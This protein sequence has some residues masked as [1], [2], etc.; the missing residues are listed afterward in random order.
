[1]TGDE[2]KLTGTIV[3]TVSPEPLLIEAIKN[4]RD[5]LQYVVD[6]ILA[7][8]S[9]FGNWRYVKKTGKIKWAEDIRKL[10]RE[11][12]EILKEKYKLPPKLAQNCFR[13]GAFIAKSVL[14]NENNGKKKAIIKK[15]FLRLDN[16]AYRLI[17]NDGWLDSI[18]IQGLC[19]V[20]VMGFPRRQAENYEDWYLG[21][22]IIKIEGKKVKFYLSLNKK[23]RIAHP[24]EKVIAVDP[25]FENIV[26]G[27]L[28]RIR[29]IRTPMQ[30]IMHIKRNH[31]EK[32]QKKYPKSWLHVSGIRKAIKRWWSRIHGILDDFV[33]Q[34]SKEIVRWCKQLGYN[35]IILEDLN[36][37]RDEQA[38][39]SKPWKERF[40]F[41][42]Y[43]KLQQWI[44]WQAKKE[45]LA[46]V[47]LPPYNTSK[48][49][50]FCNS[51]MRKDNG[52]TMKCKCGFKMNRDKLA[53]W[54]LVLRWSKVRCGEFEVLP[55]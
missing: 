20:K 3:M 8:P 39:L 1:M 26:F 19:T 47:Y 16:Q 35:T 14:N 41:F 33:K 36:G 52:R 51:E 4:F 13:Q 18:R 28:A 38:K 2:V 5:G 11:F 9:K 30:K 40:T 31:I 46:V 50:P 42:A 29:R 43:R 48:T 25:N 34:T 32:T 27:N 12:Y 24:S 21:D 44:E 45:G 7:D 10:H 49:C 54:N 6:T 17:W 55:E 22:A 23:V 53:V 37:L 15:A